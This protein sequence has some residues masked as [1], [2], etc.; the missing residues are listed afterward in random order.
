[1][2][3]SPRPRPAHLPARRVHPACPERSQ[4]EQSG[5]S[6][7]RHSHAGQAGGL[8]YISA[9]LSDDLHHPAGRSV[10]VPLRI[11]RI[12]IFSAAGR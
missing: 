3:P 2:L 10:S 12:A 4:Y 1:M 6:F 7:F 5:Q 8:S 11:V 9:A